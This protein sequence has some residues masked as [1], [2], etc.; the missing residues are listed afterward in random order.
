ML[1]D[2]GTFAHQNKR[3]TILVTLVGTVVKFSA[4][5]ML[6][7][8][9]WHHRGKKFNTKREGAILLHC[10]YNTRHKSWNI[11]VLF[12]SL[13]QSW[14]GYNCRRSAPKY[15]WLNI[16]EGGR[17]IWVRTKVWRWDLRNFWENSRK[18]VS[19]STICDEYC[20]H[21]NSC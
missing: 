19:V 10:S 6:V 11:C 20:R 2:H 3:T 21:T 7:F 4:S 17:Y 15:A 12:F 8:T 16:G 9:S 1:P 5:S 14:F 18:T 13:P